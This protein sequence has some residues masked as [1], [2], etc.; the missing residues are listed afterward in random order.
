LQQPD[1]PRFGRSIDEQIRVVAID[2]DQHNIVFGR[3]INTVAGIPASDQF[4]CY[5][6]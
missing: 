3:M 4:V 6:F 2:P 5:S 1:V